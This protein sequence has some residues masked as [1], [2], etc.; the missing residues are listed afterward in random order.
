MEGYNVENFIQKLGRLHG[1]Y[2]SDKFFEMV[3]IMAVYTYIIMNFIFNNLK[4]SILWYFQMLTLILKLSVT[5][6][7]AHRIGVK[8]GVF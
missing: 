4:C 8:S 5:S 3:K 2:T 6:L 7:V 1:G